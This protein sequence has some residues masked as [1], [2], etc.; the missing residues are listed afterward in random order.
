MRNAFIYLAIALLQAIAAANLQAADELTGLV[1]ARQAAIAQS[2]GELDE[3]VRLYTE[4]LQDRQLTN[5]RKGVILADRGVVQA[6]LGRPKSAI[7]DFNQAVELFPEYAAAYNNRGS[8]LLGLGLI[9][10]AIKDFDRAVVLA[11][12]YVAAYNNRA[13]ALFRQRDFAFAVE[14][15]T[16]AVRLAPGQAEPLGGR[17]RV[18]IA[19]DRPYSAMRDLNRALA[20]DNRFS[21]GYRLRGQV[22]ADLYDYASAAQDLSRAIAFDPTNAGAYLARGRSYLKSRNIEAAAKDF[23]KVIELNPNSATAY[24]ERGHTYILLD[25]FEQ[26]EQDLAQSLALAPRAGMTFAYRALMYKKQGQPDL[27]AQEIDKAMRLS[28][29]DAV[30]L[31][32][33]GELEEALSQTERAAESYRMSLAADPELKN[34]EFG[35]ARLGQAI[36]NQP[37]ILTERSFGPWRMIRDRQRY[38]AVHEDF[39]K[40]RVPLET[41]AKLEPRIL[42]W[43]EQGDEFEGVGVLRYTA[44]KIKTRN[45]EQE[46]EYAA[47][48]NISQGAVI[49]L[50]PDR[51]GE[52]RSQW[53]WSNGRV[54]VASLDGLSAQHIIAQA[55]ASEPVTAVSSS[56]QRRRDSW[57]SNQG[58]APAWAPWADDARPAARARP[59]SRR[60]ARRGRRKPKT[61][62]DMLLGN[63]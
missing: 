2:K 38:F 60:R 35:L 36:P 53:T 49:D 22:H 19:Q 18:K 39:D 12:G 30:V 5:D 21:L 41:V 44:G 62:F 48:V 45:G 17:A 37:V 59:Q 13:A 29:K 42:E 23:T 27:G 15:Y 25:N 20:N 4:A 11:P 47:L 1:K 16:T 54:T 33:K 9:K 31:W 32:A 63:N 55:R 61:L 34:A 56:S 3:A 58:T 26:A 7:V 46:L 8:V 6:R 51:L 43:T 57:P 28:P 14:D 40:L 10:E 50:V 24:R 52:Q